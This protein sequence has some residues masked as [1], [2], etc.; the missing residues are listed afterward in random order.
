MQFGQSPIRLFMLLFIGFASADIN[1]WDVC[2]GRLERAL[3]ALHRDSTRKNKLD[4]EEAGMLY[5]HELRSAPLE[6][7]VS[8]MSVKV[9]I[10]N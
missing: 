7:S 8:R 3:D 10:V 9:I 5:Q 2:S 6:M 1:N 4:E